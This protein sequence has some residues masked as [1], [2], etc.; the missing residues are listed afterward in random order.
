V[1]S[2]SGKRI[3]ISDA[4]SSPVCCAWLVGRWQLYYYHQQQFRQQETPRQLVVVR[5]LRKIDEK[6][7]DRRTPVLILQPSKRSFIRDDVLRVEDSTS[8]HAIKSIDL[9]RVAVGNQSTFLHALALLGFSMPC[10][11]GT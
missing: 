5:A 2:V 9:G 8:L 11:G 6:A 10:L 3:L 4:G 7:I 1:E